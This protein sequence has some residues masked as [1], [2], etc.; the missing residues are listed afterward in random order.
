LPP[1][2]CLAVEDSAHG[3]AASMAAGIPTV[4]TLNDYTHDEDFEGAR[5]VLHETHRLVLEELRLWHATASTS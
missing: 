3:L 2:D 1:R 4:I 5:M